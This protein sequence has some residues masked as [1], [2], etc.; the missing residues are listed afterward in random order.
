MQRRLSAGVAI[1][2]MTVGLAAGS[3]W[4]LVHRGGIPLDGR[5]AWIVYAVT[6]TAGARF[7]PL[8]LAFGLLLWATDPKLLRARRRKQSLVMLGLMLVVLPAT[9]AFNEYVLKPAIAIPRPSQVR[10]H[11]AGI[12]PDLES[13]ERLDVSARREF[14]EARLSGEAGREAAA[15]L[16]VRPII[17]R[18]WVAEAGSTFPSGHAFNA[19]IAA[20]LFVGG[21]CADATRRRRWLAGWWLVWSVAVALSRCLLLVHRP[22][23]VTAG[24]LAGTVVGLL[25]LLLWWR[26]AGIDDPGTVQPRRM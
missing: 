8:L 15:V 19:F 21:A 18:H 13:F 24:A 2:L 6:E 10:M 9:G 1:V 16:R 3:S 12:I 26:W 11:E 4:M 20:M 22:I 17:L 25:T 5:T 23:D 14:L 7:V